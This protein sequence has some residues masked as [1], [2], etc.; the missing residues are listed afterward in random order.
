MAE[1]LALANVRGGK[2][3]RR[4]CSLYSLFNCSQQSQTLSSPKERISC[5]KLL[6]KTATIESEK[7]WHLDYDHMLVAFHE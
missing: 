1:R 2:E 5:C 7:Q 4:A 3:A 6:G